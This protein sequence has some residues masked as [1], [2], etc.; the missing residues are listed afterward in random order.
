[1]TPTPTVYVDSFHT[2]WW[3]I[4]ENS[5]RHFEPAGVLKLYEKPFK[6]SE[7]IWLFSKT[8][9]LAYQPLFPRGTKA[10]EIIE[11]SMM[12]IGLFMLQEQWPYARDVSHHMQWQDVKFLLDMSNS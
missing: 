12:P 4:A 5:D 6:N 10:F 3:Q 7:P 9:K 11:I 2:T 8:Q 1:M